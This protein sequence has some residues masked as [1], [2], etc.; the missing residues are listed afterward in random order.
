MIF[1]RI[2]PGL[3]RRRHGRGILLASYPLVLRANI[4]GSKNGV[5]VHG[6]LLEAFVKLRKEQEEEHV[7]AGGSLDDLPLPKLSWV[8]HI[9]V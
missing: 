7:A 5:P 6:L 2:D 8:C 9:L 3:R 4:F 1:I